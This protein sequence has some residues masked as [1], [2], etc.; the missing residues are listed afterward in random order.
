MS[1]GRPHVRAHTCTIPKGPGKQLSLARGVALCFADFI[2]PSSFVKQARGI[3]TVLLLSCPRGKK[4]NKESFSSSKNL[5]T[6][7]VSPDPYT[8]PKRET[9]DATEPRS[10]DGTKGPSACHSTSCR[11]C[12]QPEPGPQLCNEFQLPDYLSWSLDVPLCLCHFCPCAR[13]TL[14]FLLPVPCFL[15]SSLASDQALHFSP[16]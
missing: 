7:W 3:I 13:H 4:T 15:P 2:L 1:M 8:F 9:L 16:A 5:I 11:L 10:L 12:S 6:C 14:A